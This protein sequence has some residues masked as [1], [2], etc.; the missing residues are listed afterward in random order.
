MVPST[1]GHSNR[2]SKVDSRLSSNSRP[3]SCRDGAS[4]SRMAYF[5]ERYT[6]VSFRGKPHH[7]YWQSKTNKSYDL[8]FEKWNSWCCEQG[9]DPI[10]GPITEVLHFLADLHKQAYQYRSL[11]S[12]ISVHEKVDGH[13]VREHSMVSSKIYSDMESEYCFELFRISWR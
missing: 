12:A 11:N 10:S 5:R 8:L 6:S 13:C 3:A 2:L 4:T 9:L 7:S 1:I